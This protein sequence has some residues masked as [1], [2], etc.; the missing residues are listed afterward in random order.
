MRKSIVILMIALFL[1]QFTSLSEESEINSEPFRVNPGYY[2]VGEDF[3]AG[4]YDIKLVRETDRDKPRGYI[5]VWEDSD[6]FFSRKENSSF[7]LIVAEDVVTHIN[8]HDGN[9]LVSDINIPSKFDF[10]KT[11]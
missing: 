4:S 6:S 1:I 3:E 2:I 7:S 11:R 5:F 9:V 8:L 10:T